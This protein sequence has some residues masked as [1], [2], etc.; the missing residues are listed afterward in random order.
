MLQCP[1]T[2]QKTIRFFPDLVAVSSTVIPLSVYEVS[3][4]L[5]GKSTDSEY[6]LAYMKHLHKKVR[7]GIDDPDTLITCKSLFS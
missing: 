7:A 5:G 1:K 2:V 3:Y 6:K 4:G